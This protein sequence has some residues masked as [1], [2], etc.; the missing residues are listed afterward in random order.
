MLKTNTKAV[1]EKIQNYVIES[2][3]GWYQDNFEYVEKK[4]ENFH[5]IA[6]EIL[7]DCFNAKAINIHCKTVQEVYKFVYHFYKSFQEMFIEYC[8]GLP[9]IL[10][11]D[12]YYNISA[13]EL[14]GNWLEETEAER[15]KYTES[16]AEEMITKLLF[17]DLSKAINYDYDSIIKELLE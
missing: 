1:K 10:N 14:L 9:S 4:A 11:C 6:Y 15:K 5:E 7:K 3:E 8:Q 13:I 17:R 12:Y 2:Y 16:K